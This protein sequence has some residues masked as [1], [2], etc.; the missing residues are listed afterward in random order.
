MKVSYKWLKEYINLEG[1]TPSALAEKMSRTGI[2]VDDLLIPGK[3]LSKLV[4]GEALQVEK[5]P[6]SDHL[7]KCLVDVGTEEPIQII[8][9]A[10]NISEG[11]K[12]IVALHGARIAGN[13]KIKKGKIRGEVSNGMI[14]SLDELGYSDSVIPKKYTDG[15]YVLPN[16]ATPGE[17]PLSLLDLDDSILDLDI[18]PNRADALSMRGVAHEVAAIYG[19]E[20]QFPIKETSETKDTIDQ[21][22]H[23]EVENIED[24]PAYYIQIINNVRVKESPLWLQ[25]KLMNAGMRPVNNIV[26]ITNYVLMEYGQPLHAF[27]YDKIGSKKI[28]VRRATEGENLKTLDGVERVMNSADIVITNGT[29]PIALAGVMGGYDSEI[30]EETVTVALEFAMFEATSIRKTG[31]KFNLRSESSARFEKGINT[32]TI[33]EAGQYAA[34]MMHE[35]AGGTIVEGIASATSFVPQN[36]KVLITLDKINRTL[37]TDISQDQVDII[38]DQLGFDHK[39][40]GQKIVISIPPRRWDISIEADIIEEV[41]RIYG[42]DHLPSTLPITPSIP[43]ELTAQQK[44]VRLSRN[45]MEAAGLTQN[46]SYVLTTAEKATQYSQDGNQAVKLAWPMSEDHSTLRVNLLSSLL[47]NASYNIA[48]KNSDIQFYE[49]GKIFLP[50]K[51]ERLPEESERIAG[52]LT[53]MAQQK[54]WQTESETVD[55]YYAKG[56][57]EEY[58]NLLGVT[59]IIRFEATEKIDWMHP[60][61]TASIYLNENLIGYMGQIHPNIAKKYDLSETYAFELNMDLLLN[62]EREIVTQQTIPKYPGTNRD[63]AIL[64]EET[65][66]HQDIVKVITEQAG[67]YLSNIQLFDIYQGKGI[68]D[69]MKSMAYSLSYLNPDATLTD[70]DI[71]PSV[72]KVIEALKEELGAI[73]R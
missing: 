23:V 66:T 25:T 8:C 57:I 35:L 45:Y 37:G 5:L 62:E 27:D 34:Q 15:I 42:Y 31:A 11:Q 32:G 36:Q 52:V 40:A 26:D 46:I 72:E 22:I 65:V 30:T 48:R 33:Q 3:E 59:D 2:E 38:L 69:G 54:N 4:V 16:N 47:E 6:E 71:Y 24:T 49:I 63:L 68:A 29:Q 43:G 1:I 13:T 14:C 67:K 50:R 39:M 17:D 19:K 61:R 21:Y 10:P 53:G 73:I 18:T 7:K 51:G 41:A 64:V 70:E 58:F 60:G 44:L 28:K 9:G 12:V 55:F 20:L 56:I